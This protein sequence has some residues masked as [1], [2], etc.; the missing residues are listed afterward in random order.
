MSTEGKGQTDPREDPDTGLRQDRETQRET[1]GNEGASPSENAERGAAE[2]QH[3]GS[4]AH[5][6]VNA[7]L[8]A[9][10]DRSGDAIGGAQG[11]G[12]SAAELQHD[13]STAHGNVNAELIA[14][15]DR[16]GD[17]IGGAQGRGE[18]TQGIV[19]QGGASAGDAHE[20]GRE[21]R[22]RRVTVRTR[23]AAHLIGCPRE[24]T[25]NVPKLINGGEKRY[26]YACRVCKQK[27]SQTAP[28]EMIS[29][30]LTYLEREAKTIEVKQTKRSTQEQP[31]TPATQ[32]SAEN[33]GGKNKTERGAPRVGDVIIRW[34]NSDGIGSD[35]DRCRQYL[36]ARMHKAHIIAGCES[37]LDDVSGTE[38]VEMAH[39]DRDISATLIHRGHHRTKTGMFVAFSHHLDVQN[40][41]ERNI[42][43]GELQVII[44]DAT[45][46]RIP[47]RLIASHGP[48]KADWKMKQSHYDGI[49]R[50]LER[51]AREDENTAQQS[52]EQPTRRL[53]VWAAD[54]NMVCDRINDEIQGTVGGKKKGEHAKLVDTIRKIEQFLQTADAY[55]TIHGAEAREYTHGKRRIDRISTT[56][57]ISSGD[58]P[59]LA[60]TRHIPNHSLEIVSQKKGGNLEVHVPTHKAVEVT[61]RFS[62]QTQATAPWRY[63]GTKYP[64]DVWKQVMDNISK[65]GNKKVTSSLR[66]QD[67]KVKLEL[68]TQSARESFEEWQTQVSALLE[69]H[70]KETRRKR[71]KQIAVER[72]A[73][74]RWRAN[75]DKAAEG[76]KSWKT[77]NTILKRMEEKAHKGKIAAE[78]GRREH[79]RTLEWAPKGVGTTTAFDMVK[80]REL[81][82]TT[83]T[84]LQV[85]TAGPIQPGEKR[86]TIACSNHEQMLQRME[87]HYD[88]SLNE[89]VNKARAMNPEDMAE[90]NTKRSVMCSRVLERV[91]KHTASLKTKD[92]RNA[93]TREN[94]L[95]ES[96]IR[97]AI[98]EVRKNTVPASDG[99]TTNFYSDTKEESW[100]QLKALFEEIWD[101]ELMTDAM[102][103][104]VIS[105][106]YKQK[107]KDKT[108]PKSYR[109]VSITP[110]EYRILTRAIQ[111]LLEPAVRE[112]I[113]KTQVA[114]VS[115]GRQMRDN[116]LLLSEMM[117]MINE[118]HGQDE[119]AVAIQVDNASAF[120]KVRWDFLHELLE[121]FDFGDDLKH[122]VK[123]L[124]R[125]VSFRVKLNG[126]PGAATSQ[127]NGIRQGCGASPLLF[128]LVQE[129]LMITI[130]EDDKL[131]G[132]KID[133]DDRALERCAADDT[134]VYLKDAAQIGHLF[135]KVEEFMTASGQQLEAS[136]SSA[137]VAGEATRGERPY[138][139]GM[140]WKVY[141]KDEADKGLG[142]IPGTNDQIQK[143]WGESLGGVRSEMKERMGQLQKSTCV[144]TRVHIVKGA[145]A[146]KIPYQA[147]IQVPAKAEWEIERTQQEMDKA[148]FGKWAF[149]SRRTAHQAKE[150]GGY[151]HMNLKKRLQAEWANHVAAM[152]DGK[153]SWM[154]LWKR[155][156]SDEYG[157]IDAVKMLNSTCA[158]R[159]MAK[160]EQGSEVQRRAFAAFG[161]MEPPT[162]APA[163]KGKTK[164]TTTIEDRDEKQDEEEELC[165]T[166]QEI[167]EQLIFFSPVYV[168]N[169]PLSGRSTIE[170]ERLARDW[171]R[172]GLVEIK[173]ILDSSQR[174]FITASELRR[175]H[176]D[177]DAKP[178]EWLQKE[179]PLEW[180]RELRR[181]GGQ[182][183]GEE[184]QRQ[185]KT[186]QV[187]VTDT[188]REGSTKRIGDLKTGD[189]YKRLVAT[190][191]ELPTT[192]QEGKD[193]RRTWEQKCRDPKV[194]KSDVAEVYRRTRH[195]AIP[196]W[197]QDI[198]YK[199]ATETD[200]V[201]ERFFQGD[202][203]SRAVCKRCGLADSTAHKFRR[204]GEVQIA[205][206]TQLTK[207]ESMTCQKCD[208]KDEWI[209]GWGW[210]L[211]ENPEDCVAYSAAH[212]EVFQ[213]LHAS[214]TVAIHQEHALQ[215]PGKAHTIVE[216]AERLARHVIDDR[217]RQM[218]AKKFEEVYVGTGLVTWRDERKLQWKWSYKNPRGHQGE[219]GEEMEPDAEIYTDGTGGKSGQLGG[220]GYGWVEV[221]ADEE[222]A[223]GYGPVTINPRHEQF[224]GAGQSTN[225]TAE[226]SAVIFALRR[227]RQAGMAAV[228]IRYDSKYAA[229]MTR[230]EW[231]P[232][233][234]RNEALILKAQAELELT[235][236]RTRVT[237]QHV[238]GHSGHRWNDRADE[239]ADLGA[240]ENEHEARNAD[241]DEEEKLMS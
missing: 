119:G 63:T 87:E 96:N 91:R 125:D 232:K 118:G 62:E 132:L 33:K 127:T 74:E 23:D 145:Y 228:R 161:S 159:L 215:E 4:T 138:I 80:R 219:D 109:P 158:F 197:M 51:I 31:L 204:C 199:S 36:R 2:L 6:N 164:D 78:N 211:A 212:E 57:N 101:Q 200:L 99:F 130:R 46:Q 131:Q 50:N 59:W 54:H 15:G 192:F 171:A 233:K 135:D 198:K 234:G 133:R 72:T 82:G 184:T 235:A 183:S 55:R 111:N 218:T 129:A 241:D 89:H 64:R 86:E 56:T 21:K 191:W 76:T 90:M 170:V 222:V 205:W 10:G 225:N 110:A 60:E 137:L 107:G 29:R 123:I 196:T 84:A 186:A 160:R 49:L 174:K 188:L 195:K 115:D 148:V 43:D 173:H 167:K 32:N 139:E 105:C 48:V 149:I 88:A 1:R 194:F 28:A 163:K 181:F 150:D 203:A 42:D 216:R 26:V 45:V 41:T 9:T 20:E 140:E 227:A 14:T 141:G 35:A 66:V 116:T 38:A 201:G 100:K 71:Q 102:R 187:G 13:G 18:S 106:V 169:T 224:V 193:A 24:C 47:M 177:I 151:G 180:R 236:Q 190:D 112:V 237:W 108:V 166:Q 27:F 70:E 229:C 16:R 39:W 136:K 85:P 52:Q 155:Q 22:V 67:G 58:G 178:L 206:K 126:Q 168:Q 79:T 69:H 179:I 75:R 213:V 122:I 53:G 77:A 230:G 68:K 104:A 209:T 7:E 94:L 25:G 65:A 144:G 217:R 92:K 182:R 221:R 8:I 3:V 154:I 231:K 19:G 114:Y 117:H 223:K 93:F 176:P 152:I 61:L 17:A 142:I 210:R 143:Q 124:Y 156:L 97:R 30:G 12:E 120:D 83:I 207:W 81:G 157:G 202:R 226:V 40:I 185:E 147:A 240:D 146:A 103:E 239:L 73:I 37:G 11:R 34:H 121:A 162:I 165:W 175:K 208:H 153:D 44:I 189:I 95:S 113:G 128:I 98:R 134:V 5:G 220:G 214:T 172:R 238:K